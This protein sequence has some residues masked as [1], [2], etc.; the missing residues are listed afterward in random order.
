MRRPRLL[1]SVLPVESQAFGPVRRLLVPE[2]RP[3]PAVGDLLAGG[4]VGRIVGTLVFLVHVVDPEHRIAL[5]VVL[6]LRCVVL[7]LVVLLPA[8]GLLAIAFEVAKILLGV[9]WM[10]LEVLLVGVGIWLLMMVLAAPRRAP[11]RRRR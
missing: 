10:L 3:P 8:W 1:R 4:P 5:V 6:V 11:G 9:G 7:G 2:A